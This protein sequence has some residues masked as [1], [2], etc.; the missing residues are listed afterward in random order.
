M[1]WLTGPSSGN[2]GSA[3]NFTID[4]RAYMQT[5][6]TFKCYD[7]VHSEPFCSISTVGHQFNF[8]VNFTYTASSAGKYQIFC[9]ND[10]DWIDAPA[11]VYTVQ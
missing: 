2:V 5:E 4:V 1:Y 11:V 10:A 8:L 9:V 7:A 6:V 3:S